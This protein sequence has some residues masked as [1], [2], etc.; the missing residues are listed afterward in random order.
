MSLDTMLAKTESFLYYDNGGKSFDRYTVLTEQV[1]GLVWDGFGFSA[2]QSPQGFNQAITAQRGRHL[3]KRI[4]YWQLPI[5]VKNALL[6][7]LTNC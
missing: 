3:G 4:T 2:E 6:N 1:V 7:R 5:E